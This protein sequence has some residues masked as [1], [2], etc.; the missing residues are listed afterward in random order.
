MDGSR[1]EFSSVSYFCIHHL[2]PRISS[3][4]GVLVICCCVKKITPKLNIF[5]QQIF[6]ILQFL[7]FITSGTLRWV[8]LARKSHEAAVKLPAGVGVS[9]KDLTGVGGDL[10]PSALTWVLAGLKPSPRREITQRTPEAGS[11]GDQLRNCLPHV[12]VSLLY[13]K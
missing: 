10:L 11:T 12:V 13:F 3:I 5:K 1:K 6:I 9:S 8:P 7:W 2:E 4:C